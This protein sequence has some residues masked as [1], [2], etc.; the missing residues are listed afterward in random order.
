[1][2]Y[3]ELVHLV[4]IIT[5]DFNIDN[6]ALL[7]NAENDFIIKT[8]CTQQLS[9]VDTTLVNGGVLTALYAVPTGFV[10]EWRLE[11]NGVKLSQHPQ[12]SEEII[13][14]SE[15][16]LYTGTPVQYWIEATKIR[17]IPMPSE[18]GKINIWNTYYNTSKFDTYPIIPL[19]EQRLIVNHVIATVFEKHGE[20][21]KAN[22]YWN[23]YDADCKKIYHKYLNRRNTQTRIIDVDDSGS[24][25]PFSL[26]NR[27]GLISE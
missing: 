8:L 25:N 17:L 9:T 3:D 14:N 2:T 26:Q 4:T 6:I 15:N 18:H 23:K 1:M 22:Y 16:E 19:T 13:Y 11:W 24:I 5:D 12:F 10:R 20:F 7:R 21:E 27:I